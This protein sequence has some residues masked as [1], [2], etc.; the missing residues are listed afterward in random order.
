MG[1]NS[2]DSVSVPLQCTSIK[3]KVECNKRYLP[4]LYRVRSLA[5]QPLSAG[6]SEEFSE[7]NYSKT[8]Q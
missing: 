3:Y 1:K 8:M 2:N 7:A 6:N 5:L 4:Y